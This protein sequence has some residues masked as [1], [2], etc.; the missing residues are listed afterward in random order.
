MWLHNLKLAKATFNL[1]SVTRA[2][3]KDC[4]KKLREGYRR[5]FCAAVCRLLLFFTLDRLIERMTILSPRHN[6]GLWC[7]MFSTRNLFLLDIK[8]HS[9]KKGYPSC[10]VDQKTCPIVFNTLNYLVKSTLFKFLNKT[11]T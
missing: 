1:S 11:P 5:L 4:Y 6:Y 3:M 2:K 8:P 10:G 7:I 9:T